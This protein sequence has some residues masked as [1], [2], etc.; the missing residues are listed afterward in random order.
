MI[1]KFA[2]E[3]P[4]FS[5]KEN[6]NALLVSHGTT[7]PP[8]PNQPGRLTKRTANLGAESF[9]PWNPG[10]APVA[11][12]L[13]QEPSIQQTWGPPGCKPDNGAVRWLHGAPKKRPIHQMSR[14]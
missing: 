10:T 14:W 5:L 2:H 7:L 4:P 9:P 12:V 6:R 11:E 3:T 8:W 13:S 1:P